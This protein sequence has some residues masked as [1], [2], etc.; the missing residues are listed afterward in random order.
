M[1]RFTKNRTNLVNGRE[2]GSGS[3]VAI[4]AAVVAD[5]DA[6]AGG[7]GMHLQQVPHQ[8]LHNKRGEGETG[9]DRRSNRTHSLNWDDHIIY[10]HS[11]LERRM[12]TPSWS[13][14][15]LLPAGVED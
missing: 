5:D 9:P 2:E 8:T 14:A 1:R 7:G 4:V 6:L 10:N 12:I 3:P 11:Q 15:S 13:E